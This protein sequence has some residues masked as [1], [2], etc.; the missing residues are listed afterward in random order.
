MYFFLVDPSW[1]FLCIAVAYIIVVRHL[2]SSHNWGSLP[3]KE[4]DGRA[5]APK[6]EE[7]RLNFLEESTRDLRSSIL[8]RTTAETSTIQMDRA[9]ELHPAEKIVTYATMI[10]H[11]M[12][13]LQQL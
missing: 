9:P 2:L 1:I 6:Q 4:T 3:D 7:H 8:Y 10:T 12:S 13:H 11:T 5:A